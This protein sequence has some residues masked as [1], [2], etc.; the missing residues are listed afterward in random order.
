VSS[1]GVWGRNAVADVAITQYWGNGGTTGLKGVLAGGSVIL[2]GGFNVGATGVG[3]TTIATLAV[4][5]REAVRTVIAIGP[6]EA[7]MICNITT[8][9]LLQNSYPTKLTGD[10]WIPNL[11]YLAA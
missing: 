5:P 6:N 3:A 1:A 11:V 9:G 4:P 10:F 2:S 8:G 7:L